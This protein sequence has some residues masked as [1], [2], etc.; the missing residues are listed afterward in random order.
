MKK[1]DDWNEVKKTVEGLKALYFHEREIFYAKIG[2]NIGFEQSGKGDN[3]ERPV[4]IVKKFNNRIFFGV[5]LSTTNKTGI[6]YYSFEFIKRKKSVAI[7]SQHKLIDAKRLD[8]KIGVMSKS[9]FKNIKKI[10]SEFFH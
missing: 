7:L 10:I 4:L 1:Y 5:P 6:F 3:Y 2:E 9:D 8:R